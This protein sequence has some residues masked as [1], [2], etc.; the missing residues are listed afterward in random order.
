[1]G[2]SVVGAIFIIH[3]RLQTFDDVVFAVKIFITGSHSICRCWTTG[4]ASIYLHQHVGQG[5]LTLTFDEGFDPVNGLGAQTNAQTLELLGGDTVIQDL[6]HVPL[7][8]AFH[9]RLGH[10]SVYDSG[11]SRLLAP[12]LLALPFGEFVLMHKRPFLSWSI[13]QHLPPRLLREVLPASLVHKLNEHALD[14]FII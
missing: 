5:D 1:M 11:L 3:K 9:V 10:P 12:L 8:S 13:C 7:R 4:L 14:L 2:K 6:L